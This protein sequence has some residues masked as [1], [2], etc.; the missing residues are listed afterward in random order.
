MREILTNKIK[1]LDDFGIEINREEVLRYLGY[2]PG[3]TRLTSQIAVLIE[4]GLGEAPSFIRP[5]GVY[6]FVE[7]MG[8]GAVFGKCRQIG[9]AICTIG[10]GL[11]GQINNL[12]GRGETSLGMIYDAIGSAAAEY[13]A[14]VLNSE[15]CQEVLVKGFSPS[16]RISPGYGKWALTEQHE[17]FSNFNGNTAGV[18]LTPDCV[19]IP[20]KSVSFA[21][22]LYAQPD[23]TSYQSLCRECTLTNCSYRKED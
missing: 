9:L 14:D 17:L 1:T 13:A 11:E 4:R 23:A 3:H 6:T 7:R 8:N 18:K 21:V 19:M 16:C 22:R 5:R 20:R 12:F 10:E 15:I 2:K